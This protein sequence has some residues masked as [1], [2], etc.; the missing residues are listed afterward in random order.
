MLETTLNGLLLGGVYALMAQGMALVWGV[1]NVVN[2]AHGALIVLGSYLTLWA[3]QYWGLDP[4]IAMPLSM[5]A[6]FVFGYIIQRVLINRVVRAEI[7][8]T[9]LVTFGL[10]ILMMNVMA[11][12]WT[13]DPRRVNPSYSFSGFSVG[14]LTIPLVRLVAFFVA[15]AIT[16]LLFL[17]LQKTQTGRAI[18]A[19]AQDLEAARLSGIP[20]VQIYG[21]TYG[22]GAALAAAAG[23]LLGMLSSFTPYSGG[24]FTLKSFVICVL[25][26]LGN[27]W[28]PLVG[29]LVLGVVEELSSRW[30]GSTYRDAVSFGL[31]VLILLV[32]P[33]GLLGRRE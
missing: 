23:S 2:I 17:F 10:E 4:I 31:L 5:V 24:P 9:L 16:L 7:F 29:G 22:I 25:G 30:L 20:V 21:I 11:W 15:I 3:F 13:V 18:R 33:S 28:G 26:G 8:F 19:T 32:R 27:A 1:M 6:L 12:G 14:P